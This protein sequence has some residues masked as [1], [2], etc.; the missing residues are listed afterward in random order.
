M[1]RQKRRPKQKQKLYFISETPVR[2]EPVLQ[3]KVILTGNAI[4]KNFHSVFTKY[5]IPEASQFTLF[6]EIW[7]DVQLH[8]GQKFFPKKWSILSEQKT[9]WAQVVN[10]MSRPWCNMIGNGVTISKVIINVF[11]RIY[12]GLKWPYSIDSLEES[13]VQTICFHT[14]VV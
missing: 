7:Y 9:S 13:L 3:C 4:Y 11:S 10:K 8:Q 5:Q 14:I 2:N 12:L 6:P 1:P